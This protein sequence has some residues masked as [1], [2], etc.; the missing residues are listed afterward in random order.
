MGDYIYRQADPK[1]NHI[2]WGCFSTVG[3]SGCGAVAAYNI[4]VALGKDPDFLQL[5]KEMEQKHLPSFGGRFGMNSIRLKLWL[6]RKFGRADMYF[7]NTE[8]WERHCRSCR[9]VVIL[10]KNKG[11]FKGNHFISGV[12][13]EEKFVFYNTGLLPR[14][15]AVTMD[16]AL[17]R[18]KKAGNFPWVLIVV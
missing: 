6:Q 10:Y 13:K 16:E 3:R 14:D 17:L 2:R 5:V 9:A 11:L 18:L 4:A 1:T 8:D 15:T 7:F 12:R